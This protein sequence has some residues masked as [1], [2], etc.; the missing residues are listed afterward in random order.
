MAE[1]ARLT[2]PG[3]GNPVLDAR[4][5]ATPAGM[6]HWAGTGPEGAICAQCRRW[7][8]FR[9]ERPPQSKRARCGKFAGLMGKMGRGV[10]GRTPACR[11]FEPITAET[12]AEPEQVEIAA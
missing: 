7:A 12:P 3:T 6:A 1:E 9:V 2:N 4:I 5:A 8:E 11:L 10:D